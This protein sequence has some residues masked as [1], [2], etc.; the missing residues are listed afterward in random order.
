VLDHAAADR[1][2]VTAIDPQ[3]G[4]LGTRRVVRVGPVRFDAGE[5]AAWVLDMSAFVLIRLDAR[6]QRVRRAPHPPEPADS[7]SPPLA[8]DLAVG[9]GGVWM[10]EEFTTRV[11]RADARTGRFVHSIVLPGSPSARRSRAA[12]GCGPSRY[13]VRRVATAHDTVWVT[14]DMSATCRG[15]RE[16][17][18]LTRIDAR[19]NRVTRTVALARELT[20]LAADG[21]G[22]WGVTCREGPPPPTISTTCPNATLIRIDPRNGNTIR[23]TPLPSGDIAGLAVSDDAVWVSQVLQTE[24]QTRGRLLR[25]D[26]AT[27]RLT[28]ALHLSGAAS[29]VV[30]AAGRAWVANIA[31]HTLT[32]IR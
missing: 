25:L 22:V 32:R 2:A 15:S 13:D 29:N 27:G 24:D 8:A 11:L 28:T 5:G 10:L 26:R 7:R 9:A 30:V 18:R 17:H 1:H 3:T 21:D 16:Q 14:S 19:T 31:T 20:A 23:R 6:T 4:H 12:S